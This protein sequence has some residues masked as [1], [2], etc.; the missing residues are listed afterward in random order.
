MILRLPLIASTSKR[1]TWYQY[2]NFLG[3]EEFGDFSFVYGRG[4]SSEKLGLPAEEADPISKGYSLNDRVGTSYLEKQYEETLQGKT[5]GKEIHLDKYGN[6]E[7][8]DTIEG[9]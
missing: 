5:L 9:R 7:S 2:F 4:V 1:F 8:V 3:S 6:M